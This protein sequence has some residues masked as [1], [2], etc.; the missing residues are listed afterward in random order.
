MEKLKISETREKELKLELKALR[1]KIVAASSMRSA[2]VVEEKGLFR[3]S[4]ANTL[5]MDIERWSSQ[6]NEILYVLEHAEVVKI[7]LESDDKHVA[8]GDLV[9][10]QISYAEGPMEDMAVQISGEV[11]IPGVD[12]ITYQSPLAKALLGKEVG[13]RFVQTKS[14]TVPTS[15]EGVIYRITKAR[16]L[17]K[18][19]PNKTYVLK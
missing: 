4:G 3:N 2:T 15:F 16:D 6:I 17:M 1:E 14:S 10:I 7:D 13:E 5:S 9:E 18:V 19:D 12:R 8:L 11:N